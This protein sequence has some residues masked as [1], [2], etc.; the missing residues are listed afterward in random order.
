M[1][2]YC[3][4]RNNHC[5]D[6]AEHFEKM[7]KDESMVDVTLSCGDGIIKAHK[8]ILSVCSSYFKNIFV[9][10]NNPY[11][12][13]IVII[14][15]MPFEDLRAIIEF[16][17]RGEVTVAHNNLKS[18]LR[19][20]EALKVKGLSDARRQMEGDESMR[21][22]KRKRRRKSR[23][24]GHGDSSKTGEMDDENGERNTGSTDRSGADKGKDENTTED[25]DATDYSEEDDDDDETEKEDDNTTT[26][27][28]ITER[29]STNAEGEIE[30]A[31]LLEQSMITGDQDRANSEASRFQAPMMPHHRQTHQQQQQL[32]SSIN[33]AMRG[34]FGESSGLLAAMNVSHSAS[35]PNSQSQLNSSHSHVPGIPGMP[36]YEAS[37]L[38]IPGPSTIS[39]ITPRPIHHGQEHNSG[40]SHSSHPSH[41]N[42]VPQ[43]LQSA[44]LLPPIQ[45]HPSLGCHSFS[46]L[47]VD[48]LTGKRHY[49][50]PECFKTF[51]E[52][53]NMK[54]HTQIHSQ[55]RN[56]F[57]CDL[58]SK[59]FAWKD[60]FNR[61][62]RIAHSELN[63]T[64]IR[65]N[66]K[67]N[68][69]NNTNMQHGR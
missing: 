64:I 59:C 11:Q 54:R 24:M 35:L 45:M 9:K 67:R 47:S 65:R 3:L 62:R 51:T 60:N 16:I 40:S 26:S 46:P 53:G 39:P 57:M 69:I 49:Q 31:R 10:F 58:C 52:K 68:N 50:C 56:R 28:I 43:N 30:P 6:L 18:V 12:Y 41:P 37:S 15:D 63:L 44:Q 55:N 1:A 25:D 29:E 32:S 27:I 36:S 48:S 4:R 21:R 17:Y 7:F 19:S 22:K 5:F 38:S 34:H 66:K 42:Q 2:S 8:M 23:K 33:Q 61:H 20:A 14:K 13:P